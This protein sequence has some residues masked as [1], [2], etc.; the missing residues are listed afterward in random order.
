MLILIKLYEMKL[1]YENRKIGHVKSRFR[2][3][4]NYGQKY[5]LYLEPEI[6]ISTSKNQSQSDCS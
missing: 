1:Y 3:R 5:D 2:C 4:R 6:V